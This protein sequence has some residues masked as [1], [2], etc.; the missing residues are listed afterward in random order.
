MSFEDLLEIRIKGDNL[1]EFQTDWDKTL[2]G[3]IDVPKPDILLVLNL[4][5]V[6]RSNQFESTLALHDMEVT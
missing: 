3:I 6:R 2:L 1:R 5:Q 4:R